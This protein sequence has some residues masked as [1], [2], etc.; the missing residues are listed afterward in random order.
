M[1]EMRRATLD[2]T[3]GPDADAI[4]ALSAMNRTGSSRLMVV[5]GQKKLVGIIALKDLL[6]FLSVKVELEEE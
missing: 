6:K 5:E 4:K 2:N 3:I 1:S